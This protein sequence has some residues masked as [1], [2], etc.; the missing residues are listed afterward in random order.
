MRKVTVVFKSRSAFNR[1]YTL[2]NQRILEN[3]DD[4]DITYENPEVIV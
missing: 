4:V 3:A 1:C 2:A